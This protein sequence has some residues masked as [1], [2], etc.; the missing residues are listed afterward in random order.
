MAPPAEPVAARQSLE[1]ATG[2]PVA[3]ATAS[4]YDDQAFL[5]ALWDIG[6]QPGHAARSVRQCAEEAAGDLTIAT[7][8]LDARMLLGEQKV[9]ESLRA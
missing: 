8:L 5:A 1:T 2:A 9:L 3:Q 7:A 6:L 4:M